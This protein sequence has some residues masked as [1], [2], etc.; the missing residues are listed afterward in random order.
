MSRVLSSRL[1]IR[2][3][4]QMMLKINK[5]ATPESSARTILCLIMA[6]GKDESVFS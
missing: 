3:K 1:M 5:L 6:V 4:Q 2:S